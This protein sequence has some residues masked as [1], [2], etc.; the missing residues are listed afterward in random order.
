[1]EDNK[2]KTGATVAAGAIGI[3]AGAAA[4][5]GVFNPTTDEVEISVEDNLEDDIPVLEPEEVVSDQLQQVTDDIEQVEVAEATASSEPIVES[6]DTIKPIPSDT[7]SVAPVEPITPIEPGPE[8]EPYVDPMLD[9][10]IEPVDPIEPSPEP[11]VDP[12]V[13]PM[14]D[15]YIEPVVVDPEPVVVDP[16]YDPDVIMCIYGGPEMMGGDVVVDTESSILGGPA[17]FIDPNI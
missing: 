2:K 12:V 4:S 9:P 5:E 15:P 13:D 14:L 3:A 10:Y 7:E 11:C 8:P 6:S 17:D 16:D 1:M